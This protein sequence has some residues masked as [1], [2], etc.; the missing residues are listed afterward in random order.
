[1]VHA[2]GGF[3]LT[4]VASAAPL[5]AAEILEGFVDMRLGFGVGNGDYTLQNIDVDTETKGEFEDSYRTTLSW[6]GSLGLQRSGGVVWGLGFSYD[7]N[8]DDEGA[9]FQS[10]ALDGYLG[11]AFAFTEAFQIELVPFIGAGRSYVDF[12]G[13]GI[14]QNS[15]SYTEGGANLNALYTFNG[16]FQLGATLTYL[17]YD[18]DINYGAVRYNFGANDFVAMVSIGVRL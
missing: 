11:Y 8:D 17:I 9:E 1:M 7:V 6:I 2:S 4:L 3:L 16:G 18:S 13:D 10:W 15:D 5:S 14:D 12:K